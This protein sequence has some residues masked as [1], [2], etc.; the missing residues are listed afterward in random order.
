MLHAGCAI[1]GLPEEISGHATPKDTGIPFFANSFS[2]GLILA[3]PFE[4][5]MSAQ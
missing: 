2:Q 5:S 3:M 4:S 1:H